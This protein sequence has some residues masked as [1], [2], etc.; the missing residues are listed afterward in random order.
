MKPA[1]LWDFIQR[2]MV[3]YCRRFGT[4]YPIEDGTDRL[5]QNV[6]KKLPF[7]AIWNLTGDKLCIYC[8]WGYSTILKTFQN[9]ITLHAHF[10]LQYSH[11]MEVINRAMWV[12]WDDSCPKHSGLE[13]RW[14]RRTTLTECVRSTKAVDRLQ[15]RCLRT[16]GE[17]RFQIPVTRS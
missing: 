12:M 14:Y 10:N 7:Y 17:C 16:Q 3:V 2:R 4:T 6:S 5:S 13:G 11:P 9:S 1:L 15:S 8:V